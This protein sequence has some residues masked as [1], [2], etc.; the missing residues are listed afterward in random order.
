VQFLAGSAWAAYE[1]GMFLMFFDNIQ[2]EERTGVLTVFNVGHATAT[3]VGSLI[4]G[5][6]LW[7]LGRNVPAY[8]AIFACS[9]ICRLL[10]LPWLARIPSR[11]I[12]GT[13]GTSGSSDSSSSPSEGRPNVRL[14]TVENQHQTTTPRSKIRSLPAEKQ[15]GERAA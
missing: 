6:F 3:V 1:L 12:D 4:G 8:M 14:V 10:T 2:P 7:T 5:A 13:D 9:S 11:P 15:V